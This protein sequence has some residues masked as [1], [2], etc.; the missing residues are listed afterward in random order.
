MPSPFRSLSARLLVLTIGFVMLAEVFI[1]APSVAAYRYNYLQN[2]LADSHI[3]ALALLA[4]P[5]NMVSDALT[6]ELLKHAGAY[7]VGLER[8]NGSKLILQGQYVLVGMN[9]P[10]EGEAIDR[11]ETPVMADVTIHLGQVGFFTLIVDAFATLWH[12]D[13]RLLHVIAPSPNMPSDV[14]D[15]LID[16]APMRAELINFS[17]RILGLSIIISLFTATLVFFSLHWMMVRPMRRISE[18]MVAFRQNPEDASR[19]VHPSTR[20][21]EVGVVERELT[22]MQ[23]AI[24]DSLTQKTRLAALGTAVGK[25]SHDL[26]NM[27]TTAR[28]VSD[29]LAE[30]GDPQVRHA[31]PT[32]VSALDR[33]VDLCTRTL[34][35]TRD[36]SLRLERRNFALAPLLDEVRADLLP[37]RNKGIGWEIDSDSIAVFADRS[38]LYRVIA[39]I[40]LNALQSGATLIAMGVRMTAEG[41]EIDIRDNGPGLPPRARENLFRPFAGSARP[42]GS[43]LGLA[44][45]REIMRA[46]G[47]DVLLLHTSGKG[48]AFRLTLPASAERRGVAPRPRSH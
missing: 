34:D 29:R 40:A 36:G 21:D 15:I 3:A 25:I 44:I 13:N 46:H 19:I 33:A 45:A 24:R 39:N 26:R 22:A 8:E 43:G 18:S 17:E 2:R 28:L 48:T 14:V 5:D 6:A 16:E 32:L 47:G 9:A 27:L 1:Y 42:G 11:D 30:S 37:D 10:D 20:S 12:S 23:L 4:T 41:I 38:Q 7:V 31:S 35:F